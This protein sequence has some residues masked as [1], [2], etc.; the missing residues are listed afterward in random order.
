[1]STGGAL[2][3]HDEVHHLAGG[4][5]GDDLGVLAAD[6]DDGTQ[7]REHEAPAQGVGRQLTDLTVGALVGQ[8]SATLSASSFF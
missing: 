8:S 2:I 5:Q 1:M 4:R 7:V 3:V 6:V